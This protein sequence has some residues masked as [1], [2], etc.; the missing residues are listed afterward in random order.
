MTSKR[1]GYPLYESGWSTEAPLLDSGVNHLLSCNNYII[2]KNILESRKGLLLSAS[3]T[4][5]V[6]TLIPIEEHNLVL[7]CTDSSI[8]CYSEDVNGL[9]LINTFTGFSIGDWRW[10]NM[11]HCIIMVNGQDKAQIVKVTAT[12]TISVTIEDWNVTGLPDTNTVLSWVSILNAQIATGYGNDLVAYYLEPGFVEGELKAF[13]IGSAAGHGTLRKGGNIVTGF[14]ISRDSGENLNSYIGFLSDN[15]EAIIYSGN[16]LGDPNNITFNGVYQTGYALGKTPLLNWSGDLII[17]TNKGF[18]SAHSIFAN[19]EDQKAQY[20]FSQQINTW[21]LEQSAKY[22]ALDGWFATALP[23]EDIIWFNIPQAGGRYVQA[24]MNISSGKWSMFSEIDTTSVITINNKVYIALKDG[25]YLFSDS[26]PTTQYIPLE[27]QTAYTNLGSELLK[28]LNMLMVR[29]QSTSNINLAFT[30]YKDFE[31]FPYY[32]W[33]DIS[34]TTPSLADEG[35]MWSDYPLPD[36]P[37]EGTAYWDDGTDA[38]GTAYWSGGGV[39]DLTPY[40]NVYSGSGL[41][42]NFSIKITA[43]VSGVKH[44]VIDLNLLFSISNTAI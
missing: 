33:V 5:Q 37:T 1:M 17:M 23:T 16:D 14:N 12:D 3:T 34:T 7:A 41:G 30:I 28:R 22:G 44:K 26:Y 43:L 29:H 15:G 21:V 24:I 11:N 18:I 42:H 36:D 2:K 6:K 38:P 19:G 4:E 25:V 40:S 10:V 8:H 31:S 20:I 13:D 39:G 35:F 27:V 32:N 9:A